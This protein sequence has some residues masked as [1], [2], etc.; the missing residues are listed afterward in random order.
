MTPALHLLAETLTTRAL[1]SLAEGVLIAF[2]A[3]VVLRS[4][5]H[6]AGTRFT[7]WFSSLVV[8][9]VLPVFGGRW[10]SHPA[11]YYSSGHAAITVPDRW[12]VY[13]L[14]VWAVIAAWFLC[15]VIKAAWHLH[16]LRR[17]CITL[18]PT[19]LDPRLRQTLRRYSAKRNV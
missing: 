11:P 2:F 19:S 17:S 5:R 6:T 13:L 8:I 12:A 15:C 9:A 4:S 1:Q 18:R 16:A 10:R 3:G 14:A 7:V